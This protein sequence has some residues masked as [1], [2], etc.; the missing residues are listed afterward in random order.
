VYWN[1]DVVTMTKW[2]STDAPL[3]V[4]VDDP[5]TYSGHKDDK[6]VTLSVDATDDNAEYVEVPTG[7]SPELQLAL[8]PAEAYHLVDDLNDAADAC[9]NSTEY[10]VH[11]VTASGTNNKY[12]TTIKAPSPDEAVTR[13]V[14][15]VQRAAEDDRERWGDLAQVTQSYDTYRVYRADSMT[16]VTDN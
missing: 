9:W 1:S 2:D 15:Y 14:E 11:A 12:V 5:D 7:L 8:S 13:A 3:T 6:P 4:T 10:V 16:T